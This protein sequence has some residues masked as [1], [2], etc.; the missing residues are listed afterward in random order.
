[1]AQPLSITVPHQLG[2]EEAH[3]RVVEGFGQLQSQMTG[4]MGAMVKWQQRWEGD[5]LHFEA[6]GLGQTLVGRLDVTDDA[7]RM[8]ID[9]PE[10]L[11]AIAKR[12]STRL[13]KTTQTLLEK[14]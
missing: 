9:L 11:A 2:R 4:G 8:E 14:R 12:V 13:M 5:R 6:K 7:L 10:I 3:R 1:M